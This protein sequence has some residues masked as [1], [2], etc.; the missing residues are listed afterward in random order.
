MHR[1]RSFRCNKRDTFPDEA[2]GRRVGFSA[3]FINPSL[4]DGQGVG[5]AIAQTLKGRGG[6][7]HL[8]HRIYKRTSGQV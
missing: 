5:K 8:F 6:R 3:G 7:A 1:E 2:P 4:T